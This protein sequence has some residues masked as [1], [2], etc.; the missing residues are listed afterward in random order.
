MKTGHVVLALLG[1]AVVGFGIAKVVQMHK[2]DKKVA[3]P[4]TPAKEENSEFKNGDK[5]GTDCYY[6]GVFS[7]EGCSKTAKSRAGSNNWSI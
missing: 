6:N 7:R 1:G 4:S 3:T 5:I 2:C